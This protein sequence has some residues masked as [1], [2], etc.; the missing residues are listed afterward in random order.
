[1]T[2]TARFT[3]R[4]QQVLIYRFVETYTTETKLFTFRI[5]RGGTAR[6]VTRAEFGQAFLEI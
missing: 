3:I 4:E 6:E 1:M 5:E 2:F